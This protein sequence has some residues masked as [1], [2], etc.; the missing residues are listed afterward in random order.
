M[1]PETAEKKAIKDYLDLKDYFHF[2]ILQGIA[3]YKG[4]P[5]RF[6]IKDGVC[7]ALEIKTGKKSRQSEYQ[8]EF[9]KNWERAGGEY[10]LGGI[11]EVIK[12][13]K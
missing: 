6:L 5:D 8:K 1:T 2:P 10:I 11:D 3:A 12:A 4:L 7:Y 9:Q 13:I